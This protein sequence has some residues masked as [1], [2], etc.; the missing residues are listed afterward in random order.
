MIRSY[1]TVFSFGTFLELAQHLQSTRSRRLVNGFW[2]F[3]VQNKVES[4]LVLFLLFPTHFCWVENNKNFLWSK[5]CCVFLVQIPKMNPPAR[6]TRRI[7]WISGFLRMNMSLFWKIFHWFSDQMEF[8]KK[9][10][11]IDFPTKRFLKFFF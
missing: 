5:K 9:H 1:M 10:I 4:L 2:W 6:V 7:P 8:K 3:W 11:S